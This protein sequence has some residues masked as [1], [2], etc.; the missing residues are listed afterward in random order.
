M[1]SSLGGLVNPSDSSDS[2]ERSGTSAGSGRWGLARGVGSSSSSLVSAE[3]A[4]GWRCRPARLG[5]RTLL[6]DARGQ[7]GLG[8]SRL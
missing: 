5:L 4:R 3:V 1:R 6:D 8:S 2:E 7:R